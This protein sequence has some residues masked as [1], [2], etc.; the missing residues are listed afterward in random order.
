MKFLGARLPLRKH[1]KISLKIMNKT[2]M[3]QRFDCG[4]AT[5]SLT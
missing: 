3:G 2:I 1:T 4:M 5:P